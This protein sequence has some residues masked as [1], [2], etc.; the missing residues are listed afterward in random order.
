MDP[1]RFWEESS[2]FFDELLSSNGSHFLTNLK[3]GREGRY[4]LSPLIITAFG[5]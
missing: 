2:L 1:K 4:V 5:F 3:V